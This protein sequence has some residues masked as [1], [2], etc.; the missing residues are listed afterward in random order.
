[1]PNT[2]DSEL[3]EHP[4]LPELRGIIDQGHPYFIRGDKI[5][6][7]TN[8]NREPV[9][10]LRQLGINMKT[11]LEAPG[12]DITHHNGDFDPNLERFYNHLGRKG[13]I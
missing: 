12:Y 1:M 13:I 11:L 10:D 4:V 6:D 3:N 7:G 8:P 5:F 9:A 2:I